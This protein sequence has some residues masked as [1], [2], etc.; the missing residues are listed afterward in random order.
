MRRRKF[1]RWLFSSALSSV[2]P[3][4]LRSQTSGSLHPADAAT[5]REVAAAVLPSSLGRARTDEIARQFIEWLRD[6]KGGADAGY[7]YGF[8]R[9]QVVPPNPG[10]YYAGQLRELEAASFSKLDAPARRGLLESALERAKVDRLPQR[11]NGQHVAADLM[12]WFFNSSAGED[13]LYN[14]AI[15]RDDCR[16]LANSGQRP[17]A[18][19]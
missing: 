8:P 2:V 3:R 1:F 9:V 10:A 6:Y 11:P 19:A 17:S 16:G 7:G 5:L 13:L 12:A 4:R 14:A 18:I 15:R